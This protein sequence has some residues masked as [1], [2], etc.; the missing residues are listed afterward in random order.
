[1]A[2]GLAASFAAM[3]AAFAGTAIADQAGLEARARAL[4]AR[5]LTIDSHIDI[6]ANFAS[7]EMDPGGPAEGQ[8]DLPRMRQGGLDAA[9]FI[10]YVGQGSRDAAGYA[11]AKAAAMVKFNAIR[12]LALDMHA[13]RIGLADTASGV[14]AIAASGRHIALIGIENGFVIGKDIGLLA[15]YRALGARYMTLAHN[16]HNDI[17]DSASPR[18]RL[19]DGAAEHGGL[20]E[21]GGAV[22]AEM[23]RLGILVDVS[24]VSHDAAMQAVARS[25]AP[26]IASHSNARALCDVPRN[27][28][29]AAMR[30]IAAT[31]GVVQTTAYGA[32]VVADSPE[33][34]AAMK[35]LRI[36]LGLDKP[37]AF[38]ALSRAGRR[39]FRAAIARLNAHHGQA[40]LAQYIDH[41][42]HAVKV[43]G[44][45][46]VGISSDFNGGGGVVGW[47]NA[48]E[49]PNVT[50]EL[51]RR[52]Y[53]EADIVKLWGENLLRV[54]D[55][56]DLVAA[57]LKAAEKGAD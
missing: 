51:L 30:A 49:T 1:M 50:I 3:T 11:K 36:K 4:H 9:F 56:A 17:A 27:L 7:A 6:P 44:I 39:E 10:V 37:G 52:G 42:D 20:S 48:A 28:T 2:A 21:F 55:Q 40:S 57:R 31:G 15:R 47:R 24:H 16:G 13:D 14:R 32:F 38:A 45:D 41:I 12:R 25:L 26:V 43:I 22:V 23:N 5:V 34:K 33:K 8:V 35:A 53:S 18:S 29:D 54:M 19:G 46:H